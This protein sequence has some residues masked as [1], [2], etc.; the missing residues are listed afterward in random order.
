VSAI[1]G[2]S[3]DARSLGRINPWDRTK[4]SSRSDGVSIGGSVLH[5]L[6]RCQY[7]PIL[8]NIRSDK[9]TRR[10]ALE[11]EAWRVLLY[12]VYAALKGE[13]KLNYLA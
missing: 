9:K 13:V 7:V 5:K 2:I 11:S 4:L 10:G 12:E 3:S 8:C 6:G 1:V